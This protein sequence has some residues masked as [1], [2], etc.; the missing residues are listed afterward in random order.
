MKTIP[1]VLSL[2]T[3]SFAF[4]STNAQAIDSSLAK[5]STDTLKGRV[6]TVQG[7]A[8]PNAHLVIT[9]IEARKTYPVTTDENG[10]YTVI[11]PHGQGSYT[12]R[13][14][15]IG[16]TPTRI[17]VKRAGNS[18]IAV[19]DIKLNSN[20]TL[21]PVKV[22]A[23]HRPKPNR[24]DPG[25]AVGAAETWARGN[26]G[27]SPGFLN[28]TGVD[29]ESGFSALGLSSDQNTVLLDGMQTSL[30]A[31]P[32]NLLGFSKVSLTTSDASQGG[33]SGAQ[34][35]TELLSTSNMIVSNVNAS[36]FPPALQWIDDASIR[37]GQKYNNTVFGWNRSSPILE[38]KLFVNFAAEYSQRTSDLQFLRRNNDLALER[39]GLAPDSVDRALDL[40]RQGGIPYSTRSVPGNQLNSGGRF[41]TK[42]T[43]TPSD[44]LH[45]SLT[46]NGYWNTQRGN[47]LSLVSL[48]AHG[49]QSGSKGGGVQLSVSRYFGPVL[50]DLRSYVS[51]SKNESTPYIS[52]PDG[53]IYISS[54]LPDGT[55]ETG[56]LQ[57]GGNPSL[58]RESSS[59]TWET[60]GNIKWYSLG[61]AHSYNVAF[62]VRADQSRNEQVY[63]H[64]GTFTY[65]SLEDFESGNPATFSR[66][67][68]T[69]Q[70]SSRTGSAFVAWTDSWK[71]T[72]NFRLVPSVRIDGN[73]YGMRPQY[74][75]KVEDLFGVRN[76]FVPNKINASPR[77]N[78]SWTYGG[79]STP[80]GVK[81]TQ[82]S[83]K[84][85]SG[86]KTLSGSIGEYRNSLYPGLVTTAI[87]STG[88]P[89]SL[90]QVYCIGAAVP[91]PDWDGYLADPGTIPSECVDTAG[92]LQFASTNPNVSLFDK[93]YN[94]Q[95]SWRGN[96]NWSVSFLN[97]LRAT[98][99]GVLSLNLNQ[100]STVDL[101]MTQAPAFT[102]DN[103]GD[104]P[105]F[106]P[107]SA[108]VPTS[109][110]ISS[111]ASRLY[112]DF[113]Q[114]LSYRSDLRS[115]SRQFNMGIYP[116]NYSSGL[117][118]N[119][120][121]VYTQA[122]AQSRGYSGTTAGDPRYIEWGRSAY[123]T[124]HQFFGSIGTQ[125]FNSI[126]V[127]F[128]V[129]LRSGQPFTPLVRGDINGD[130]LAFNDRAFV[131]DSIGTLHKC[132]AKQVGHIAA[133]N[134]CE[135]PWTFGLNASMSG[136]FDLPGNAHLSINFINPLTG[137][138]MALHGR[139]NLRG[140]GQRGSP[141]PTL[142][143]VRGF[144]PS[145]NHYQYEINPR[146]GDT[147][148]NR[149]ALRSP[150]Q[151]TIGIT[152]PVGPG[153]ET[154]MLNQALKKRESGAMTQQQLYASAKQTLVG[155]WV[156]PFQSISLMRDSLELTKA[157]TAAIDT[158]GK[159]YKAESDSLWDPV[160]KEIA[161][162]GKS[163]KS[164]LIA[165]HIK[166]TRKEFVDLRVRW[167]IKIR[168]VLTPEQMQMLPGA[169]LDALDAKIAKQRGEYLL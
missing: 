146:F 163:I 41:V 40:L 64:Y 50:A 105:V 2:L 140:W 66:T 152:K 74:N 104:R 118:W 82:Y 144:D 160:I 148:I 91:T 164:D 107:A 80:S 4:S 71:V 33:F 16:S 138:D 51:G 63:N 158:M 6:I 168:E 30:D 145:T 169:V 121:Y 123:A 120:Q 159:V 11:I 116:A 81:V 142:L 111:S 122:D 1:L 15:T 62:S 67:L 78:F 34:A 59:A 69:N 56:I 19:Q 21:E 117:Y 129:Q 42:F 13:V 99:Q 135:G 162:I 161:D 76:D 155:R 3:S 89:S 130:L 100:Q 149:S 115:F 26:P 58:P 49:G 25:S 156:N 20:T 18:L 98:F 85:G 90:Q 87:N 38:D 43:A 37:S 7:K 154:Q 113:N 166:Q 48:P 119:L 60:A 36:L 17:T 112:S 86:L 32:S 77:L 93:S 75:F 141:D 157:Q 153:F 133:Q 88:L 27:N 114:V 102:L 70:H 94:S 109:G 55:P 106:A 10:Y 29:G 65:Y 151:I 139:N 9:D 72:G 57:F 14:K 127:N 83:G 44:T 53:R 24:S 96:L 28:I 45:V 35:S 128:G 147:K 61:G 47:S 167:G 5:L 39:V 23:K 22:I 124:K 73:R 31:I 92:A 8:I 12:I 110:V 84:F 54:V 52:L 132:L 101:N 165:K 131:F 79:K 68:G 134:S 136:R 97:V 143:I 95:R 103:E 126:F 125:F 46:L 150:F 108:I 137:L